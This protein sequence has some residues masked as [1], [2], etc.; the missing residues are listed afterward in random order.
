VLVNVQSEQPPEGAAWLR[1]SVED[2][3]IGIPP[4][5]IGRLFE[6]FTQADASTTRRFGGTG[7]GL[8]ISKQLIELMGGRI[9]A[10]SRPGEG[11]VFSF[12]LPLVLPAEHVPVA[13]PPTLLEGVRVL[14]VDDNE[15]NRRVLHEQVTSWRMPHSGVASAQEALRELREARAVGEPYH[16][17]ILDY[18]MPEMDGEALARAIKADPALRTTVLV[19]LTS[20]GH[21]NDADRLKDAGIFACM[22][23]PVRQSRLWDVLAEA[24][25]HVAHATLQPRAAPPAPAKPRRAPKKKRKVV[26]RVLVV[27]D[28]TTNQKVARL[29][30]ENLGCRVDV[31]CNG[32]EAIDMLELLPYDVVFM[33]CEMP[34]MDGYHATAEIRRRHA[35]DRHVPVVAMTAKAIQGDR[36]RC[37]AA[38]MDDYIS[39]PVRLEDLDAA[40]VRWGPSSKGAVPS[41]PPAPEPPAAD[42]RGTLALDPAVTA[43]LRELAPNDPSVL[44][45]IYDAFL[46]SG[47]EYLAGI[48]ASAEKNDG[49]GL[50]ETA[51]AMKGASANI[52]A[53]QLAE[54]CRQLE[55]LGNRGRANEAPGTVERLAQEFARVRSDIASQAREANA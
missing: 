2:T 40:L 14:V 36:E 32:K 52:G 41:A 53:H 18:Q 39:K 1:F 37:L 38:G 27:D 47:A 9:T 43:R 49:A 20:L 33:D 16:I 13:P 3:G 30:L 50:R 55:D 19:M 5:K 23:K 26:A 54:I 4:D 48:R 25:G 6:K 7:L 21:P 28:N 22:L 8:A 10:T 42:L 44:Q 46:S 24:W 17:A 35:D 45:E 34:E 11:S 12:T 31:A 51:H 15:V 29:M